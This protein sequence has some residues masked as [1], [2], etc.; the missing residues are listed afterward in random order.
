[1]TTPIVRHNEDCAET[2]CKYES[3]V[4][5]HLDR[6]TLWTLLA[7]VLSALGARIWW[8]ATHIWV[9]GGDGAEYSRIAQNLLSGRGFVG[10]E[11]GPQLYYGPLYPVLIA[12]VSV[13]T[14]SFEQA[15]HI[16]SILSGTLLV[17]PVF[18]ISL[19]IYGRR[20]ALIAASLVAFHPLLVGYSATAH[21]ENVYLTMMTFGMYWG[22]RAVEVGKA[23]DCLL[24]GVF[25]GLAYLSRVEAIANALMIALAVLLLS[26]LRNK[27]LAKGAVRAL[28]LLTS[29]LLVA[30]PYVAY[31]SGHVGRIRV[32]AKNKMNYTIGRRINAG[33]NS[34]QAAYGI[35]AS[36]QEEGPLLAPDHFANYTPYP[37]GFRDLTHYFLQAAV[38]N[39]TYLYQRV[40]PAFA[41]GSPLLPMLVVIGIFRK[42]WDRKRL[43]EEI[44]LLFA[45]G[46]IL[47]FLLSAHYVLFRYALPLLP[48]LLLWA[49]KGI[50]EL[51][52]WATSSEAL[53][54]I[55]PSPGPRWIDSATRWS[56][57]LLLLLIA[58][59][60]VVHVGVVELDEESAAQ[61]TLKGAGLWIR[62]CMQGPNTV[63]DTQPI[64]PYY[65]DGVYLS[66]PWAE[67]SVALRYIHQKDPNFIVINEFDYSRPYLVEWFD[68][69]IPDPRAKL[70]YDNGPSKARLRIYWWTHPEGPEMPCVPQPLSEP[71]QKSP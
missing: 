56:L 38:R 28:F 42:A 54:E 58:A 51:A 29:F 50:E 45:V 33:M 15:A 27:E 68:R 37:M 25:L 40:L 19:G 35:N 47:F 13:V 20:V 57:C 24:A 60:G 12:C 32:E 55:R 7:I 67:S 9:L 46:F 5:A 18:L 71:V 11:P 39:K 41:L 14:S 30:A 64:V 70:M 43:V 10:T 31:L 22:L 1:M 65:A 4:L 49:A 59:F 63:M 23:R 6:R 53:L 61:L 26:Y 44:F 21:N 52:D 8:F 17:V 66:L 34:T 16:V 3:T 2:G 69:G 48:F 62:N 36:L